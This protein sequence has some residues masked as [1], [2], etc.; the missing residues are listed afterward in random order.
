MCN[1]SLLVWPPFSVIHL[2][3]S[4][5]HFEQFAPD[6]GHEEKDTVHSSRQLHIINEQSK[7]D[8]VRKQSREIHNLREKQTSFKLNI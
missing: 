8:D 5:L 1:N 6:R 4:Y 3:K 2:I 7:Q